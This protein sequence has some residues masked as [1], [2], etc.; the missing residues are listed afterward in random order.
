MTVNKGDLVKAM[1]SAEQCGLIAAD[2]A[3]RIEHEGLVTVLDG[4][5]EQGLSDES[6]TAVLDENDIISPA[7]VVLSGAM[8]FK[9]ACD[10][11]AAEQRELNRSAD[12][13]AY[14][15]LASGLPKAF[16]CN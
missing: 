3:R 16:E 4:F 15:S 7:A 13:A 14:D 5:S 8:A 11:L 6:V 2:V 12:A 1:S 10:L 9:I